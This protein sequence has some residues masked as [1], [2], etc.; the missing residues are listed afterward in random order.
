MVPENKKSEIDLIF[1]GN[2]ILYPVEIR[3]STSVK[4]SDTRAFRI[5]DKVKTVKRGS[6]AIVCKLPQPGRENVLQILVWYI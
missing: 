3:Q 5:L 1:E 4:A 2:G 6:G